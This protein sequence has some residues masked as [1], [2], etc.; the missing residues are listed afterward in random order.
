MYLYVA[1]YKT[2]KLLG[3]ATVG[4]SPPLACLNRW[5]FKYRPDDVSFCYACMDG[6]GELVNNGEVNKLLIK[7]GYTIRHMASTSSFQ[8]D[9]SECPHSNIGTVI[10][11][12]LH[13]ANLD[14]KLWPFAF[15]YCLYIYYLLPRGDRG[16]PIEYLTG[17]CGNVPCMPTF[18]CHV[19]VKPPDK[20]NGKLNQ[21]FHHG[22][23]L[24]FTDTM[25][26]I[27]YYYLETKRVKTTYTIKYDVCRT[28]V[29]PPNARHPHDAIDGKP[30]VPDT[31]DS[32]A[33]RAF[34]LASTPNPL[35]QTEDIRSPDMV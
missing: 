23:F 11:A 6:G 21:N 20:H 5:F 4:K 9:P 28:V 16:V 29:P 10:L 31:A 3:I 17:R 30:L 8:N 34:G 26:H 24:C 19:V 33:L 2:D 18:G 12:M 35:Y 22:W 1:D 27:Y 25:T 7:Y 32:A 13:G 14:N 15:N